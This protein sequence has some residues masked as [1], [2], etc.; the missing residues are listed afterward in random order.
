M[1]ATRSL[2]SHRHESLCEFLFVKQGHRWKTPGTECS[3]LNDEINSSPKSSS[4]TRNHFRSPTKMDQQQASNT[5][6]EQQL[7]LQQSRLNLLERNNVN[8]TD[9]GHAVDDDSDDDFNTTLSHRYQ[10]YQSQLQQHG[11]NNN[12]TITA[13]ASSSSSSLTTATPTTKKGAKR[14]KMTGP[15]FHKR[16]FNKVLLLD[17]NKQ[18][19]ESYVA[20]NSEPSTQCAK[21]HFC[22]ICGYQAT[23]TCSRCAQRYCCASCYVTHEDTRCL[24]QR[25]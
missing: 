25:N 17:N 22:I 4:K 12:T 5:T 14:Q 8:D 11:N 18:Q 3:S 9:D 10:H 21:R 24:K 6:N 16:N 2:A 19:Y 7:L 23:Y 20:S 13:S 15:V 1:E